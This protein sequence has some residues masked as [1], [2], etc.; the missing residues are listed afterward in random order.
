[1]LNWCIEAEFCQGRR[2]GSR[3]RV[4][5]RGLGSV[6][7]GWGRFLRVGVGFTGLGSVSQGWGRFLR[8]GVG[9]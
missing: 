7:E 1:M 8:V 6:F 2:S 5:G 4:G 9:F 3:V